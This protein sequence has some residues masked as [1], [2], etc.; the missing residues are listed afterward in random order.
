MTVEAGIGKS[1][2]LAEFADRARARGLTV[3]RG[4]ATEYERH[5]PFGPFADAFADLDASAEQRLPVLA[6]LSPLLCGTGLGMALDDLH[7]AD[8]ASPELVDHLVRHP[9]R[10]PFLLVVSSRELPVPVSLGAAL[11]RDVDVGTVL[12]LAL[13]PL[14]ERECVE[15]LAGELPSSAAAGLYEASDGNPVCF[16]ALLRAHRETRPIPVLVAAGVPVAFGEAECLSS[17]AASAAA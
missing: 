16:L 4:R 6:E 15:E 2:L 12:R 7:W 3:L 13:G 17:P 8:P 5:T 14:S 9:V 1:R 11:I 10:A